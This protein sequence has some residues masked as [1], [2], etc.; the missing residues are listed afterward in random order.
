LGV[1]CRRYGGGDDLI[2]PLLADIHWQTA[3]LV[4]RKQA[5]Y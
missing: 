1:G 4:W 3:S 2:E 5:I